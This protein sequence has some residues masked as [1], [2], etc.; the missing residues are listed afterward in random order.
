MTLTNFSDGGDAD[1]VPVVASGLVFTGSTN[2]LVLTNLTGQFIGTSGT[3]IIIDNSTS[4][5]QTTSLAAF[6]AP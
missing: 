6:S 2:G 5:L 1:T 4:G 3:G